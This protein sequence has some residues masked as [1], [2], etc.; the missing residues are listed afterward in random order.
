MR[1]AVRVN[2]DHRQA[3]CGDLQHSQIGHGVGSDQIG[4]KE[5]AIL[6][7]DDNLIGVIDHVLVGQDVAFGV[8]DDAG[9]ECGNAAI[10][11]AAV[12]AAVVD[13]DYRRHGAADAGVKAERRLVFA[14]VTVE[15]GAGAAHTQCGQGRK[16]NA[17]DNQAQHH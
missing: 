11:I 16:Q 17:G 8:H 7:R 1:H 13:V 10:V 9:T 14:V 12:G 15:K 5:A 4:F 3:G 6:Q 2:R